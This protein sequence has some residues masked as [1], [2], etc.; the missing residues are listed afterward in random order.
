MPMRSRKRRKGG[1]ADEI[2]MV[3]LVWLPVKSLLR[4]HAMEYIGS[5]AL[6]DGDLETEDACFFDTR[7]V[8][9]E[10]PPP[11]RFITWLWK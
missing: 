10:H 9:S 8:F 6:S 7:I 5:G 11:P 2:V 1:A 4:F 3:V